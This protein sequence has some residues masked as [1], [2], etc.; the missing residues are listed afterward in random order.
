MTSRDKNGFTLGW[1]QLTQPQKEVIKKQIKELLDIKT[2][3]GFTMIKNG[4]TRLNKAERICITALFKQ[5]KV[6]DIFGS[7]EKKIKISEPFYESIRKTLN[8]H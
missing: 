6:K 7:E 8:I 1:S 4:K 2:D 3:G 5:F